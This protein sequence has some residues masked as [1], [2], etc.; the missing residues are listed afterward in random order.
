MIRRFYNHPGFIESVVDRVRAAL[1]E[2]P[3]DRREKAALIFT[4]HSIPLAMAKSGPYEAQLREACRL[5]A[6]RLR[7][8]LA[9]GVPEPQRTAVATVARARC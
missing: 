9:T 3:E 5:V 1:G 6:E 7:N 2:L 4:A 8:R